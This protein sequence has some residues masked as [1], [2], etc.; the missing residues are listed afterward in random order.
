MPGGDA[1]NILHIIPLPTTTIPPNS[2]MKLQHLENHSPNQTP[3][4]RPIPTL[5]KNNSIKQ[6]RNHA[7]DE[8]PKMIAAIPL[9]SLP[10]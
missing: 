3:M 9:L 7:K 4:L 1:L 5:V 2:H 6:S 8:Q 10:L